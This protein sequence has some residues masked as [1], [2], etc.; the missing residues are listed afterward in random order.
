VLVVEE[1]MTVG[2]ASKKITRQQLKS[3]MWLLVAAYNQR[4]G[5]A[6]WVNMKQSAAS[7]RKRRSGKKQWNYIH[8]NW[9]L[10]QI[11]RQINVPILRALHGAEV[12]LGF[13]RHPPVKAALLHDPL[14]G[15]CSDVPNNLCHEI[16]QRNTAKNESHRL[17]ATRR[18]GS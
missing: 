17:F 7:M 10:V 15:C 5:T 1:M 12:A 11:R 6:F 9:R 4:G 16:R 8:L 3:D 2:L 13:A 18:R 14:Q